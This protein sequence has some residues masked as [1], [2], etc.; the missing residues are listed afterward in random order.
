MADVRSALRGV[1][2]A[3]LVTVGDEVA[4]GQDLVLVESMKMEY[5]VVGPVRRDGD[6]DPACR[7]ATR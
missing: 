4:A 3:V 2:T 6:V 5:P 7:P 1:V